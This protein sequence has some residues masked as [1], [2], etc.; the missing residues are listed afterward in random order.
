MRVRTEQAPFVGFRVDMGKLPQR[1]GRD[2][3]YGEVARLDPANAGRWRAMERTQRRF[4]EAE[5][6][7]KNPDARTYSASCRETLHYLTIQLWREGHGAQTYDALVRLHPTLFKENG[8]C[9]LPVKDQLNILWH[10]EPDMIVGHGNPPRLLSGLIHDAPW[11]S[12]V[13]QAAEETRARRRAC[14][15]PVTKS[16]YTSA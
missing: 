5:A 10:A 16:G 1:V 9:H 14:G 15:L 2:D 3:F 13:H 7:Y 11:I 6:G 4:K 8:A 12:M